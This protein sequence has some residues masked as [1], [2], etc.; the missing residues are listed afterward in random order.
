MTRHLVQINSHYWHYRMAGQGPLVFLLHASPRNSAM[1]E[2][3]IQILSRSFT[4]V[5][6]DTPG[7][8]LSDPLPHA[9]ESLL[10]YLPAFDDFFNKISSQRHASYPP[11]FGIYGTATGAQLG[12]AYAYTYPQ[13]VQ[14]LYIDNAAHFDDDLR[15][16][17]LRQYFPDLTPQLDGT[18]LR[19][20]WQMASQFFTYFPWFETDEAHRVSSFT[21]NA[22]MIHTAAMEFLN[23]GPNYHLAYKAAFLHEKAENLA[24]VTIPITLFRWKGAI[25]L[26]Y[27][28]D[29]IAKGLSAN[30]SVV[31]TEAPPAARFEGIYHRM[32][33]TLR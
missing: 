28:D 2:P 21:P 19:Q 26:R 22:A 20:V 29:L 31:E 14:H 23:A 17:I 7:Y 30:V 4:V 13:A 3:L 5:A 12:I 10:D 15:D 11:T 9:A 1:F 25:L 33:Q 32:C 6:P 16:E 18:H 27:I 24:K 8:G